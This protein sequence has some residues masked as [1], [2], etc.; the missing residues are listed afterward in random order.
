MSHPAYK[1]PPAL[2]TKAKVTK[3]GA[4][5]RDTT[6]YLVSLRHLFN[7]GTLL[8]IYTS[9]VHTQLSKK[10]SVEASSNWNHLSHL[11]VIQANRSNHGV[12]QSWIV[13]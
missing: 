10:I 12:L 6:V 3:G 9:S 2:C 11:C 8:K 13:V 4:Y 1:P 7:E 5:L